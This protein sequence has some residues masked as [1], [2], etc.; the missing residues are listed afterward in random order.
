MGRLHRTKL[1]FTQMKYDPEMIGKPAGQ[2]LRTGVL[3]HGCH[4]EA[5]GWDQVVWGYR[6]ELMGR[7][8]QGI[9]TA[10]ELDAQI[11]VVGSGASCRLVEDERS[12]RYGQI[13]REAEFT[14]ETLRCR[15]HELRHFPSWQPYENAWLEDAG[16]HF[17]RW[18]LGIVQTDLESQTTIEELENAGHRFQKLGIQRVA[19]V[20]SP[21]HLPRVVR[22]ATN[23]F[24]SSPEFAGFRDRILAVPSQTNFAG[25]SPA[26]VQVLEPPHRPDRNPEVFDSLRRLIESE[27]DDES[28]LFSMLS[29]MSDMVNGRQ[30]IS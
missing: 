9:L 30:R 13:L 10:L 18:L 16:E 23:V 22:D 25:T 1:R 15:F 28:G 26:D 17:K 8:P 20:S 2:R 12:T 7:L 27:G 19:L 11:V 4:L 5:A 6:S 24:H 29:E 3:V 14:V 21:T